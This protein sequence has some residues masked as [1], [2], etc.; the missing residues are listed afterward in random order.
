M[1]KHDCCFLRGKGRSHSPC[2]AWHPRPRVGAERGGQAVPGEGHSTTSPCS[3][4]TAPGNLLV[5]LPFSWVLQLN[6]RGSMGRA[7]GILTTSKWRDS[8]HAVTREGPGPRWAGPSSLECVNHLLPCPWL[9]KVRPCTILPGCKL[10]GVEPSVSVPHATCQGMFLAPYHPGPHSATL[11]IG[12]RKP[13]QRHG[14]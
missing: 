10:L 13:S 6:R 1:L 4:R 9:G 2:P 8:G 14:E 5:P 12:A 3:Q 11:H 7:E